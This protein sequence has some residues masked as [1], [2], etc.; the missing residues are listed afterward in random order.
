M[1]REFLGLPPIQLTM[2]LGELVDW[3]IANR[4]PDANARAFV[5]RQPRY[6]NGYVLTMGYLD[7]QNDLLAPYRELSV[8]DISIEIAGMFGCNDCIVLT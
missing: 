5:H 8:H 3:F 7:S 2:N 4:P 1:L 6:P